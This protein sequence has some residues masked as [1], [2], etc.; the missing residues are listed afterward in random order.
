MKYSF[1]STKPTVG[2]FFSVTYWWLINFLDKTQMSVDQ[3]TSCLCS[4]AFQS[5]PCHSESSPKFFPWA[6]RSGRMWLLLLLTLTTLPITQAAAPLATMHAPY[7][8]KCF[9]PH[10]DSRGSLT[11]FLSV[12]AQMPIR[13]VSHDHPVK[14]AALYTLP[15]HRCIFLTAP[16]TT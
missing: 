5:F 11:S 2:K 13:R 8:L 4:E 14:L 3:V 7:T 12:S 15:H 6:T 10:R 16:I 1:L 9:S